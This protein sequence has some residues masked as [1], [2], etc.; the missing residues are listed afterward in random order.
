MWRMAGIIAVILLGLSYCNQHKREK[1]QLFI[2]Q[3]VDE[4][5]DYF[6]DNRDNLE[7]EVKSEVES[8][9]QSET[10]Q[11]N[12]GRIGCTSDCSGHEAGFD[13]AA[14]HEITDAYDCSGNSNS[15]IEGCEAY[16]DE[17][18]N[19]A[20]ERMEELESEAEGGEIPD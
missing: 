4:A 16:A 2:D 20:N 12:Y 8:D 9:L 10:Y 13:W 3:Q 5:A 11:E 6:A 19:R 17:L 7:E 15:F 1:A 14:R 18:E